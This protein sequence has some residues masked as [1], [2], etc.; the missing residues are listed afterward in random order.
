LT[1]APTDEV[2]FALDRKKKNQNMIAIAKV[3]H[4][5]GGVEGY[6][7]NA[8]DKYPLPSKE[9]HKLIFQVSSQV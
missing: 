4:P 3:N 6:R 2:T 8:S 1:Y 7:V 5:H 9:S